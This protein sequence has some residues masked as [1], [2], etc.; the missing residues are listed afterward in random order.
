MYIVAVPDIRTD[1][2]D[3]PLIRF[4]FRFRNR[5]IQPYVAHCANLTKATRQSDAPS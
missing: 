1:G 5:R 4:R 3:Y 2:G